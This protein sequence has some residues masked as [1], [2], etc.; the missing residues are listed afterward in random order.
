MVFGFLKSRCAIVG[1]SFLAVKSRKTVFLLVFSPGPHNFDV[2]QV[3]QWFLEISIEKR[4]LWV[5]P[6]K[7]FTVNVK[8]AD[9]KCW[10]VKSASFE[11]GIH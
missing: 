2:L 9:W 7:L 8:S 6:V 10:A 4:A 3:L 5:L 1:Y 11:A